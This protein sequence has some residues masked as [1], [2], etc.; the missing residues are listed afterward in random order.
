MAERTQGELARLFPHRQE[1]VTPIDV[2]YTIDSVF[3]FAYAGSRKT[4]PQ[5]RRLHANG[6]R[7]TNPRITF[8]A[9]RSVD[10][11]RDS[12]ADHGDREPKAGVVT[13]TPPL[14]TNDDYTIAGRYRLR[15]ID[16]DRSTNS[17]RIELRSK[18]VAEVKTHQSYAEALNNFEKSQSGANTSQ[19]Q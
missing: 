14:Y 5:L 15:L 10:I 9:D 18:E 7:S 12:Q 19:P 17:A 6:R 1:F 3:S 11:R 2:F 13:L 4:N 8:I 16:L